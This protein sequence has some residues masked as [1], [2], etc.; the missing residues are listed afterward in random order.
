MAIITVKFTEE[1]IGRLK[2]LM[3]ELISYYEAKHDVNNDSFQPWRF[4]D[5]DEQRQIACELVSIL[6]E[7][8][9]LR[10]KKRTNWCRFQ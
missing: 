8:L 10:F 4:E 5:V 7:K 2:N 9:E 6:D 3:K 1:E